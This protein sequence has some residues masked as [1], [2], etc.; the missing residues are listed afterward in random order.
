M[1]VIPERDKI[2]IKIMAAY[3]I[4]QNQ[5]QFAWAEKF[6]TVDYLQPNQETQD[7][8]GEDYIDLLYAER[9]T[10]NIKGGE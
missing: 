5:S 4:T 1:S 3:L 6:F 8:I 9:T 7:A 10:R 2:D